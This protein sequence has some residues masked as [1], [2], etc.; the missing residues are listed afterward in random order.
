MLAN[1]SVQDPQSIKHAVVQVTPEDKGQDDRAQGAGR[2]F[3]NRIRRRHDTA[4][5]P[6]KTLPF[7]SLYVEVFLQGIERSGGRPRVA[8]GPKRN[9]DPK[10]EAVFGR[11]TNHV[12]DGVNHLAEVLVIRYLCATL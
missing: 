8:V 4:F 11:G 5:E 1:L 9:V 3:G 6:R 10:H 2:P 7:A 12:V